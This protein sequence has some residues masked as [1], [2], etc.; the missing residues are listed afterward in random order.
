MAVQHDNT[1]TFPANAAITAFRRVA[2]ST[3]GGVVAAGNTVAGIGVLQRD[4]AEGDTYGAVVRLKGAGSFKVSVTAAPVTTGDVLYAAA[5]GQ[6]A[7]TG[8]VALNWRAAESASDDGA[9]I[10]AIPVL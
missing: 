2:I 10:E 4:V 3:N 9:V 6:V 1:R 5:N 7:P 8:T